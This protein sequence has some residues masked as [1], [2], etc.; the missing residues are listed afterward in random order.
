MVSSEILL[1]FFFFF[2]V[3]YGVGWKKKYKAPTD[4]CFAI[5]HPRLQQPKSTKYIKFLCAED[6][7]TLARWVM[8]IRIAKVSST[9]VCLFLLG[10]SS[11]RVILGCDFQ[12]TM[13]VTETQMPTKHK[14][15]VI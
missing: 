2:Q 15:Y 9:F 6:D 12:T 7:S 8:G 11:T 10:E 13:N 3:Y 5:K 4:H 1:S 14:C